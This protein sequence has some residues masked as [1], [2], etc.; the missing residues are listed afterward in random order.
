[1]D[2][3]L[4]PMVRSMAKAVLGSRTIIRDRTPLV[5]RL[6]GPVS[7]SVACLIV[8]QTRKVCC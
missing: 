7:T 8:A 2:D 6:A 3:L 5:G 4:N 1:M